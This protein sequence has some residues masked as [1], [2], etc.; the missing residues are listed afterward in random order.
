[1]LLP[2]ALPYL[3]NLTRDPEYQRSLG[4]TALYSALPL[5]FLTPARNS[6]LGGLLP[7]ASAARHPLFPG[8]I[9]GALVLV[10][11]LARAWRGTRHRAEWIFYLCLLAVF[12]VLALGP[13]LETAGTRVP[14]PFAG[15]YVAIPGA[16]LLRAPVRFVIPAVLAGSLL[17]G[18]GLD[19]LRARGFPT[20]AGTTLVLLLGVELT[21]VPLRLLPVFPDGIPDAYAWLASAD[22]KGAVVELPL[23]PDE[24]SETPDEARFALYSLTHG[25]RT[26]NGVGGFVPP[27]TR[28]LRRVMQGFPDPESLELLREEGVEYVV[29][30]MDLVPERARRELTGALAG[31][32]GVAPVYEEGPI[33]IYRVL[34]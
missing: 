30:H 10:A 34:P 31:T 7:W 28:E 3:Q 1:V 18:L 24:K 22:G 21:A 9:A 11:V 26:G 6:I 15:M 12:G 33:L 32:D 29:V 5:D 2:F 25:R 4:E 8:V 17:A 14:L 19:R 16:S 13:V 23:P 20:W 27:A